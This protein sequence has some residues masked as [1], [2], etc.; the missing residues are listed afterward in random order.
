MDADSETPCPYYVFNSDNDEG[1]V[2]VSGEDCLPDIVGYSTAGCFDE[3]DMPEGLA[4]LLEAYQCFVDDIDAGEESAIS[5]ARQIMA[6]RRTSDSGE[7]NV[8]E[9]LLGDIQ[10]GQGSPY[11]NQCPTIEG[12]ATVAGCASIAMAQIMKYHNCPQYLLADIPGYTYECTYNGN[13]YSV[14]I[15]DVSA[16][17]EYDW[18]NMLSSYTGVYTDEQ[19][20]AVSTLIYHCGVAAKTEYNTGTSHTNSSLSMWYEYFGF[21]ADLVQNLSAQYFSLS[22]WVSIIEKELASSRPI[23]MRGQRQSSS[24]AFVCD[25]MDG[26]GLFHI[27]W[28]WKGSY[29]GYFDITMLNPYSDNDGYCRNSRMYVGL[30]PDNGV[31][32][33]PLYEKGIAIS[34]RDSIPLTLAERAASSDTFSGSISYRF[35][36]SANEDFSGIVALCFVGEDEEITLIGE[37]MSLSISAPSDGSYSSRYKTLTFSYAFPVGVY[38]IMPVYST[39]GGVTWNRCDRSEYYGFLAE[40]TET[41][42]TYADRSVSATASIEEELLTGIVNTIRLDV[43][44]SF[45]LDYKDYLYFYGDTINTQPSS[46]TEELYIRVPANGSK[47]YDIDVEVGNAE[48]YYVWVEDAN[49][50]LLVDGKSFEITYNPTPV[51]TIT[52]VATNAS[53]TDYETKNAFINSNRVKVPII[54]DDKFIL[55][56]TIVNDGGEYRGDFYVKKRTLNSSGS[57]TLT[58]IRTTRRTIPANSTITFSDTVYSYEFDDQLANVDILKVSDGIELN[59]I[60]GALKIYMV[61]SSGYYNLDSNRAMGYF[62]E[63]SGINNIETDELS[64]V[65][66]EGCIMANSSSRQTIG[67][68]NISGQLVKIMDLEAG[69]IMSVSLTPGIYIIDGKKILVR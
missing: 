6:I 65:V 39:D 9:P 26:T 56:S 35:L 14:I 3:D 60:S 34:Y 58:T 29:N 23:F 18:D 46:C 33:E 21:D 28:G 53:T 24:H 40:S 15:G 19:A 8:V 16:G 63:P 27:N 1:F 17:T 54:Y 52:G 41:A 36:N 49:G 64:I 44:N 13:T 38:A 59:E 61:N 45:N 55:N 66:A 11:N 20:E 5:R 25:G 31:E 7:S 42:L 10:W 67:I 48:T 57:Y 68:Y 62:Y 69:E 37:S 2:I 22:D 32:D 50:N 51:L 12:N 30:T 4:H 47:S 43:S